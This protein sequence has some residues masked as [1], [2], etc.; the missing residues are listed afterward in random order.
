MPLVRAAMKVQC[1]RR[2]VDCVVLQ[3]RSRAASSSTR[4][5][6]P[7]P[8]GRAPTIRVTVNTIAARKR[9]QGRHDERTRRR[10]AHRVDPALECL[11][12][13]SAHGSSTPLPANIPG[14][15]RTVGE[16]HHGLPVDPLVTDA[17][18]SAPGVRSDLNVLVGA[19]DRMNWLAMSRQVIRS[20][21]TTP[22]GIDGG[23]HLRGGP[24]QLDAG[25]VVGVDRRRA[26]RSDDERAR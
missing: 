5:V 21:R 26:V 19:A 17:T 11:A 18:R 8:G 20:C 6:M 23:D 15:P 3:R 12:W 4:Y 13:R 10:P 2:G 25:E 24:G 7:R 9:S 16:R 22:P 14:Y 1:R